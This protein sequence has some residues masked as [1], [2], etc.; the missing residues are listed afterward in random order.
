MSFANHFPVLNLWRTRAPHWPTLSPFSVKINATV[1]S[2]QL[3]LLQRV[4]DTIYSQPLIQCYREEHIFLFLKLRRLY[5]LV[6]NK[7]RSLVDMSHWKEECIKSPEVFSSRS[8]TI[9][10]RQQKENQ[11]KSPLENGSLFLLSIFT[12][13]Q[14]FYVQNYRSTAVLYFTKAGAKEKSATKLFRENSRF[15]IFMEL[16]E[17]IYPIYTCKSCPLLLPDNWLQIR[18][19]N[20]WK[21]ATHKK[22]NIQQP[23]ILSGGN[24]IFCL[25]S[26]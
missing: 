4:Y 21:R 10:T 8:V 14:P 9:S 19:E 6:D 15:K 20:S 18:F 13:L 17:K 5:E 25:V 7:R 23:N 16:D 22:E 26:F 3:C 1:W 24:G 11:W 2:I 12:N